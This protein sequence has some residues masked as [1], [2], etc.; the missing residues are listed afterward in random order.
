M[1]A[2]LFDDATQILAHAGERPG[3]QRRDVMVYG[4]YRFFIGEATLNF[5]SLV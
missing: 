2:Q 4:C 1:T 5:Q 3:K